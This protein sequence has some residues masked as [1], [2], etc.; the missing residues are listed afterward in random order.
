MVQAWNGVGDRMEPKGV[1]QAGFVGGTPVAGG[2]EGIAWTSGP[3]FGRYADPS[4]SSVQISL[5]Q[6]S[7]MK[8]LE[9][10]LAKATERTVFV[11]WKR[12]QDI[13]IGPETVIDIPLESISLEQGIGII[14]ERL[15]MGGTASGEFAARLTGAIV[16]I[17]TMSTFDR[18][19][20]RIASYDIRP[21]ID[22]MGCSTHD[23]AAFRILGALTGTIEPDQWTVNG[24]DAARAS[25]L[26]GRLF[27]TAP[28]RFHRAVAWVL[29]Q[30]GGAA[31]A[32]D[33]ATPRFLVPPGADPL[34][35]LLLSE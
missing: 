7:T 31:V 16:E 18:R 24:G 12:L 1:V 30:A 34:Q 13:G 8:A 9:T 28:E 6:G 2:P 19:E 32:Q 17:S 29:K 35:V 14:N 25:V 15:T 5:S 26:N 23:E 11:D 10:T 22:Q 3:M 27:V 21:L 4:L 33:E 20:Q